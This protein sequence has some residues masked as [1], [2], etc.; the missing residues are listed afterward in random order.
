MRMFLF[1]YAYHVV[2]FC[3]FLVFLL[4]CVCIFV[5]CF[6][7]FNLC[8]FVSLPDDDVLCWLFSCSFSS[9]CFRFFFFLDMFLVWFGLVL[10]IL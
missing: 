9:V 7:L 4:F 2:V 5:S 8:F 3:L 6:F 10:P 1:A